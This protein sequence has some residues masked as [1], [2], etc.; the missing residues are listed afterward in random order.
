[1]SDINVV[2]LKV[3]KPVLI[4][5]IIFSIIFSYILFNS[6]G[7]RHLYVFFIGLGLGISLYQAAFGFTGGWRNFIEKRDSKSLRAQIIM[8]AL[9]VIVFSIFLSKS[10]IKS[11]FIVIFQFASVFV[12][13]LTK[14]GSANAIKQ[15]HDR[16]P[17][18]STGE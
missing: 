14:N 1:M 7:D 12:Y 13:L 15:C 9:A 8:L 10:S 5:G 11:S 6:V 3:D 18:L 17:P 16:E 2:K 4:Y